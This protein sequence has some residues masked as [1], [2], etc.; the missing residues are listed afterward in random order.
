MAVFSRMWRRTG[1]GSIPG[2][3]DRTGASSMIRCERLEPRA[4]LS[5]NGGSTITGTVTDDVGNAY[6]V[7]SFRGTIDL[8]PG[9]GVAQF[10]AVGGKDAFLLKLD[11]A[12]NYLWAR[13]FGSSGGDAARGVAINPLGDDVLIVGEFSGTMMLDPTEPGSVLT[14]LGRTDGFVASFNADGSFN[15]ADR[16]G[17]R[18]ADGI[19]AVALDVD[20]TVIVGGAFSG[21]VDFDLLNGG[22]PLTAWGRGR[23]SDGFVAAYDLEGNCL[24]ARN[25]GGVKSDA[26]YGVAVDGLG[27][28]VAVGEFQAIA[29]LD[30]GPDIIRQRSRGKEDGFLLALD[31]S[32]DYLWSLAIGGRGEDS[33]RA[34]SCDA[35]GNVIVGGQFEKVVDFDP[36]SSATVLRS[37]GDED[38]FVAK[39]SP[40][41]DLIWAR[42]FGS[43][44]DDGIFAVAVDPLDNVIAG[45]ELAVAVTETVRRGRRTTTRIR[46]REAAY[47]VKLDPAGSI[48]W[49]ASFPSTSLSG[50]SGDDHDDDDDDDDDHEDRERRRYASVR[51]DD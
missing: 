7:G 6:L 48:L 12:G 35:A 47:A 50:G 9:P 31:R 26:V 23:R 10:T 32:G 49:S 41:G 45:G 8:D 13:A 44:E 20:G 34:V 21:T 15:W 16:F 39:Y 43:P 4:L 40:Q 3:R 1:R 28:I 2:W 17:G 51:R 24:W 11:S 27:T 18:L 25:V 14:S 30:P 38:G 5:G 33:A 42:A 29:D 37:R 46:W 22:S 19:N 36:S